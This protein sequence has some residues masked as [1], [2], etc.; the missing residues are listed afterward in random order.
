MPAKTTTICAT[1]TLIL[2]TKKYFWEKTA[3]LFLK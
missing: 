3:A 1:D 2:I